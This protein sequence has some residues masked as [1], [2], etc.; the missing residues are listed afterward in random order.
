MAHGAFLADAN[1][2]DPTLAGSRRCALPSRLSRK[3]SAR[4]ACEPGGAMSIDLERLRVLH[5]FHH[6]IG[7]G[8]AHPRQTE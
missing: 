4:F 2:G 3:K 8:F 7:V 6:R 1:A 5:L